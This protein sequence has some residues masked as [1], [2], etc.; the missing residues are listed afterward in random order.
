[1]CARNGCDASTN[2][3]NAIM[4][5]DCIW[6]LGPNV[7]FTTSVCRMIT[8][9]K[10][11]GRFDVLVDHHYLYSI[12]PTDNKCPVLGTTFSVG[13]PRTDSPSLDRM[14]STRGYEEGNVQIISDLAN[15]M[16]HN[17]TPEQLKKF[18]EYHLK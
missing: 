14:D 13:E 6:L 15:K 1:M 17:A 7:Q 12:W 11:R 2:H 16:K 5:E 9:A 3:H 18:C 8:R 10:N 4:C